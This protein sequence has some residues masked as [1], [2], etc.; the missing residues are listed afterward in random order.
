MPRIPS[1]PYTPEEDEIIRTILETRPDGMSQKEA[2]RRDIHLLPGRTLDGV[3]YRWH[4]HINN[5]QM[6][7]DARQKA[8][9]QKAAKW[10]RRKPGKKGSRSGAVLE[11]WT[12]EED[13]ILWNAVHMELQKIPGLPL[14]DSLRSAMAH[15]PGRTFSSVI[16]R[17]YIL[18]T[19][20]GDTDT[21]YITPDDAEPEQL[22]ANFVPYTGEP[23]RSAP[24]PSPAEAVARFHE[25]QAAVARYHQEQHAA[26]TP[27]QTAYI[28][29]AP[30]VPV[31]QPAMPVSTEQGPLTTRAEEFIR[32]M[33]G[34]VESNAALRTEVKMLR[35]DALTV[36]QLRS[37]L[38]AERNKTARLTSKIAEMEEDQAAF[39]KLMD[40][41]RQIGRAESGV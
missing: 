40:K 41:A 27:S 31:E 3:L 26:P 13:A 4:Q 25:Q 15:L 32:E 37:E 1:N 8:A 23:K 12:P 33:F 22:A 29:P 19:R 16:N 2:M 34:I 39:L 38:E 24:T 9:Q 28:P 6:I 20:M 14:R 35:S 18:R 36:A 7:A 5:K 10:T 17:Y 30:S 21:T 11:S